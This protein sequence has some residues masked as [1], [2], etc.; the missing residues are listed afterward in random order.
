[1]SKERKYLNEFEMS[2]LE[3][4]GIKRLKK[5]Y[6]VND[7]LDILPKR[8]KEG[9]KK[10][11]DEHWERI[12][13]W[14]DYGMREWHCTTPYWFWEGACVKATW[15]DVSGNTLVECLLE[16]V[17]TLAKRGFYRDYLSKTY[18]VENWRYKPENDA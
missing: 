10:D 6:D 3:K 16:A 17:L 18:V 13:L 2:L 14:W 11:N 4:Y 8:W 12:E 7:L 5:K 1:M 15:N 9:N